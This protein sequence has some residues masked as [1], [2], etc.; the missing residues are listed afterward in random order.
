VSAAERV[1][2]CVIGAGVAGLRAA[3]RLSERGLRVRVLEARDRVGGRTEGGVL[4]GQP[5]DVGGQWIGPTQTRA[6]ALCQELG[7]ELY[8]QF[9]DGDRLMELGGRLSRYRGTVPRMSLLGLLDAGQAMARANRAARRIDPAAPWAA[10]EAA[11]WDRMT[12]EQWLQDSMYTRGG[13][14]LMKI[15]TRAILTCEPHEASLLCFL[16]YVS[17]ADKIET[18]AEVHGDGA[19]KFKVSGGAFQIAQRIAARLPAGSVQ[20]RKSVV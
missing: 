6:L 19:Q 15:L 1:D 7:L 13:R 16:N 18:L 10:A 11:R 20:D 14:D 4:C 3:Q 17:A 2:A 8:P 5:V 9:A 12:V